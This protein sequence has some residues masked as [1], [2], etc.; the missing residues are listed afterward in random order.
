MAGTS[1]NLAD[2]VNTHTPSSSGRQTV[3]QSSAKGLVHRLSLLIAVLL[4]SLLFREPLFLLDRV[5]QLFIGI[6]NL[7][8]SN[9]KL[10]SASYRPTLVNTN[11]NIM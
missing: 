5:V 10:E 3:F 4:V 1:Q 2:T 11:N 9:K 7:L 8:A 6:H